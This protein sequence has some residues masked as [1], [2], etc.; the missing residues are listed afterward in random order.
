[1]TVQKMQE[2]VRAQL[3]LELCCRP[4][5]FDRDGYLFTEARDVPG[6]RP[7]PRG[8]LSLDMLTMGRGTV[9]SA[10]AEHLPRIMEKLSPLDQQDAFAQPFIAGHSLYYLP[11]HVDA[12]LPPMPRGYALRWVERPDIP[13]LYA[14]KG[15]HNA[16]AY[17]VNHPRPD[18]LAL[19]AMEGDRV[20]GMAACSADCER[21]WQVGI[22]V[23]PPWRGKGIAAA[24]VGRLTAE[25]IRRGFVP[26][27]GTGSTNVGSQSVAHRAGYRIAWMCSYN[28]RWE[29][30]LG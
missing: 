6:R 11:E 12:P 23:L 4:E 20:I 2:T 28:T 27:Y 17:D 15:F 21:L 26:Y 10:T 14:L 22:D 7:F 19:L 16:I 18:V 30:L 13:A 1:M 5:D 9:V 24:L 25:I 8:A 3:A 29:Y